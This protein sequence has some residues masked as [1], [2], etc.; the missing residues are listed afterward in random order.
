MARDRKEGCATTP[1]KD[2]YSIPVIVK[3]SVYNGV[4]IGTE[5]VEKLSEM[6]LLPKSLFFEINM[7]E[8]DGLDFSAFEKIEW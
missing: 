5:Y 3:G 4:E 1:G 8:Y 7:I 6:S 2:N